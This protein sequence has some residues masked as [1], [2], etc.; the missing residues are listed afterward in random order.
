ML[1]QRVCLQSRLWINA[2]EDSRAGVSESL[3]CW[4]DPCA[5][6][7][8]SESDPLTWIKSNQVNSSST[9][10]QDRYRSITCQSHS[11]GRLYLLLCSVGSFSSVTAIATNLP[12]TQKQKER[13]TIAIVS[14]PRQKKALADQLW[15]IYIKELKKPSL[16]C[17]MHVMWSMLKT[18]TETKFPR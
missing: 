10:E 11:M 2:T 12:V 17:Y 7:P 15:I 3:T 6:Q 14:W 16:S 13:K 5:P 8:L 18:R 9:K 1:S 4:T